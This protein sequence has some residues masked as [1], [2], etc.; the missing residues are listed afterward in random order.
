MIAAAIIGASAAGPAN[1]E[2]QSAEARIDVIVAGPPAAQAALGVLFTAG[3]Y[4]RSGVE[5]GVGASRDGLSGRF[6]F[7]NRFHLDPFREHRWAP[8]AGGGLSSRFEES[9][10]TRY[11]LLFVAGVDGP[12]RHGLTTAFEAGFGGGARV[13]VIVRRA[14]AERR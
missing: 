6:D 1:A 10:K 9:R 7:V 4:V 3:T 13:G 12:V 8:Y 14:A 5:A 2:A 11:Y